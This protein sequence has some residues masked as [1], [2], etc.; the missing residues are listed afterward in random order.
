MSRVFKDFPTQI[1]AKAGVQKKFTLD[2]EVD[3][4]DLSDTSLYVNARF[5]VWKPDGTLIINKLAAIERG[6]NCVS[7]TVTAEDNLIKNAGNWQGEV[8]FSNGTTIIDHTESFG[9]IIQES[10]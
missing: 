2:V 6:E 7:V 1:V 5:K 3:E 4:I 10:Y 9:Y 8:E